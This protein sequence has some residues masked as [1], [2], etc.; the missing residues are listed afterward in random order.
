[1][2]PLVA[3][4]GPQVAPM[5]FPTPPTIT[6]TSPL[7]NATHAVAYTQTF[8]ATGGV[9]AYTWAA[10][11]LPAGLTMSTAGVLSGTVAAAGGP[12]KI[13]VTVTGADLGAGPP[14]IFSL[15]VV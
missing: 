8:A 11:N 6:T 4:M 2:N 14:Q 13:S 15:T 7:P 12:Y 10:T 1:M 5:K 9:T 3:N